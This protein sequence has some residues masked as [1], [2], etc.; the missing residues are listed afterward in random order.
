MSGWAGRRGQWDMQMLRCFQAHSFCA[1]T[2]PQ[3]WVGLRAQSPRVFCGGAATNGGVHLPMDVTAA[4]AS[5]LFP[6][7]D[8]AVG[9][10]CCVLCQT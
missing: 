9:Y 2:Q 10:C 8:G 5:Q 6:P 4:D 3:L 7:Q 1:S